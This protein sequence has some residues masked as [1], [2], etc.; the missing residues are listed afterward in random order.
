MP[1]QLVGLY[2]YQGEKMEAPSYMSR[3]LSQRPYFLPLNI[4]VQSFYYSRFMIK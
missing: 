4:Q 3:Y 2:H 1:S